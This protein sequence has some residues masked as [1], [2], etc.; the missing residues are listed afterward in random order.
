LARPPISSAMKR[1]LSGGMTMWAC[2]SMIMR[3][4]G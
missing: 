1:K 4:P 3:S 2:E